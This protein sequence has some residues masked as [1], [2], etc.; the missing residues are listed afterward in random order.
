MT[1]PA[2]SSL[3]EDCVAASVQSDGAEDTQAFLLCLSNRVEA[4]EGSITQ[5]MSPE[6][7]HWLMLFAGALVFMMQTGFAVS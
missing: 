4:L 2:S 6:T 7:T 3:F 1:T 5:R